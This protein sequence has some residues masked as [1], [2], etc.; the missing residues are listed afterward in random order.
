MNRIIAGFRRPGSWAVLFLAA[1]IGGPLWIAGSRPEPV[2]IPPA[3]RS[4][5]PAPAFEVTTL[6]GDT[7]ALADLHGQAVVLNL[8]ATWCPPCRAEMPAL[9]RIGQRYADEG[10]VI[11][12]LNQGEDPATI[13]AFVQEHGLTFTIALDPREQ[14]GRL[15]E[16]EAYPT[17]FFIGRDGLIRSVV[18]GGPMAEA[19]IEDQVRKLLND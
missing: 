10:L 17:T 13:A 7:L 9:E 2:V 6:N 14:I 1:L 16:L 8:W 19:L 15:Y 18:Q 12:A 4:G 3:P 11:L 5:A